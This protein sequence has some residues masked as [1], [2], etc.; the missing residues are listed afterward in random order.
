MCPQNLRMT[1]SPILG[2]CVK[3]NIASRIPLKDEVLKGI[4]VSRRRPEDIN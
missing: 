4:S 2:H 1:A 3:G